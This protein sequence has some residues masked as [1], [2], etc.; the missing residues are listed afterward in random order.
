MNGP[1]AG[2]VVQDSD[3]QDRDA[4]DR[5]IQDG[6]AREP[7]ASALIAELRGGV[8]PERAQEVFDSLPAVAE[9]EIRGRWR[10]SVAPTG[11]PMDGPLVASGWY[12]KQFDDDEHVHP[13][14]FGTPGSFFAVNPGKV[15]MGL[16]DQ[17]GDKLPSTLPP[18]GK[19]SFRLLQTRRHR[20]RLRLISHRGTV[21]AAMVYDD[22]PIID[23]FRWLGDAL[24]GS[25]D[26]RGARR[27]LFFLLERDPSGS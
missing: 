24:L 8:T 9:G 16:L 2:G 21:S 15:P 17:Y 13:L 19:A 26:Q 5:D 18:G 25:M 20:A 1:E 10:G 23:H 14:L 22:L 12:G 27:P 3:I 7:D 11:H 6:D 4:Q